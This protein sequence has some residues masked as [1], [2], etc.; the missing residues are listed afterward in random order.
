GLKEFLQ[1]YLKAVRSL[2]PGGDLRTYPGSPAIVQ[3]LLRAAD[4][5]IACELEPKAARQLQAALRGDR[6]AKAVA[7]DGWTGLSAYV[8]PKERRGL[9]LV[10]P[11]FEQTDDFSRLFNEL[12]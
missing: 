4:R 9:V 1:P 8:P 2:N 3:T 11:P 10:D 12:D 7:I 6:R 5:L